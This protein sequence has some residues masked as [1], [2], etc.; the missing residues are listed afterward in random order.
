MTGTALS[1]DIISLRDGNGVIENV[2]IKEIT[3][4]EVVYVDKKGEAAIPRNQVGAILYA[5]GRYETL[6]ASVVDDNTAIDETD[7]DV[8]QTDYD[9][10]EDTGYL[11]SESTDDKVVYINILAYG[12]PAMNF[13]TLDHNYDGTIVEYRVITQ[14]NP[15]PEF[16]YLGTSPFAYVTETEAKVISIKKETVDFTEIRPLEVPKDFQKI[17]FRLSKEGFDTIVVSPK[18]KIRFG[19]KSFLLPLDKL[20][21]Q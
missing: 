19:G 3:S 2:K 11:S 14:N 20:G 18:V 4:Q 10:V 9:T 5:D 1:Q 6:P 17:E 21:K 8:E 16:E 13:Y 15:D 7:N 12:K